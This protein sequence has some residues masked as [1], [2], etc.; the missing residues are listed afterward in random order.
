[1]ID[2]YLIVAWILTAISAITTYWY[3]CA[4]TVF[5]LWMV[6]VIRIGNVHIIGL[7]DMLPEKEEETCLDKE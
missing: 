1:M 5:L 4:L 3:Y 6:F 7:E 2:D